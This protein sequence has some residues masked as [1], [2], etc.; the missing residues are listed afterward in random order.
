MTDILDSATAHLASL[1]PHLKERY[2][3]ELIRQ[4]AYEIV[5]LRELRQLD[6]ESLGKS[7][8]EYNR[9]KEL[10]IDGKHLTADER[11]A[12]E[13]AAGICEEHAEEYD[14]TDSS[15]IAATLRRLLER[16]K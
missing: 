9:M 1:P 16:L 5:Q 7:V 8:E 12:I 10:C 6:G 11:E 14:G 13:D 3:A 2:S 15:P 4:L